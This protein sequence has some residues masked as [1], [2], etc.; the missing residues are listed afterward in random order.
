MCATRSTL[1]ITILLL[2]SD[3]VVRSVMQDTL[4]GDGYLVVPTGDLGTAVD[5]LKECR[6]DLLITRS[7]VSGMP[8]H[9]AAMY[10]RKRCPHMGVLIVGGF[11]D[12]DRLRYREALENFEVFPKPYPA[13][14]LL[15][16]V[17]EVLNAACSSA[18]VR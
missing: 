14:E 16:K 17:K 3:K 10:L 2:V 6:A 1:N 7:Y 12:D 18:K 8:G 13:A 11:L 9:D 5:R 4:E 15:E